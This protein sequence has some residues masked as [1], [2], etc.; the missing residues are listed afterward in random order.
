MKN[1]KNNECNCGCKNINKWLCYNT[2]LQELNNL[3]Y[4]YLQNKNDKIFFK[5][6]IPK[7]IIY[8]KH[9]IK[10]KSII[11]TSFNYLDIIFISKYIIISPLANLTFNSIEGEQEINKTCIMLKELANHINQSKISE[12]INILEDCEKEQFDIRYIHIL[13]LIS[14]QIIL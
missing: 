1:Y 8:T 4:K 7:F 10:N 2:S 6:W 5:Q 11:P 3:T 12:L 14:K 9:I 13:F